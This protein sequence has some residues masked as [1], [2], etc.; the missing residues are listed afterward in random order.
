MQNLNLTAILGKY[1]PFKKYSQAA[2]H[3]NNINFTSFLSDGMV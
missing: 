2:G 1:L 3:Q